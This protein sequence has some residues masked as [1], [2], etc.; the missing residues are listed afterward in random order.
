MEIKTSERK[1]QPK[2][3]GRG[4]S[5]R[6]RRKSRKQR[7]SHGA[8]TRS[9]SVHVSDNVNKYNY[10]TNT[11]LTS[12]CDM[13]LHPDKVVGVATANYSR[14]L[15]KI[16]RPGKKLEMP[17]MLRST[18]DAC[19]YKGEKEKIE[20]QYDPKEAFS[21]KRSSNDEPK[22]SEDLSRYL[23]L[24]SD[25]DSC[26]PDSPHDRYSNRQGQLKEANSL[27]N[28]LSGE[29]PE[30]D[31]ISH[32]R[33]GQRSTQPSKKRLMKLRGGVEHVSTCGGRIFKRA[34]P[35]A[36]SEITIVV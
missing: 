8:W 36:I 20:N 9:N 16:D 26:H 10:Q 14:C 17:H 33:K 11:D 4:L 6:L 29:P 27:N 7:P 23:S 24:I 31:D 3:K 1:E 25:E 32:S 2:V 5:L 21:S 34:A 13:N 19:N 35:I 22:R 28:I 18:L 12:S 30:P 15:S